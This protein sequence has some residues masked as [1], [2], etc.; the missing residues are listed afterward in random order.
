MSNF[1]EI[2]PLWRLT[3]YL[4][5]SQAALLVCGADPEFNA[6]VEDEPNNAPNGY[7]AVR[8][9]L[10][11]ALRAGKIEGVEQE[12][13]HWSTLLDPDGTEL[14]SK[15]YKIEGSIDPKT[16]VVA[17]DSMVE[18]L[19]SR[20]M[21]TGFFFSGPDKPKGFRDPA[22]PRYAPKLAA[23]VEAWERFDPKS[24]EQGTP[25]QRLQKWLRLNAARFGLV[26]DDGKPAESTIEMLAKVGNWNTK[27][28]NPGLTSPEPE[29]QE[30]YDFSRD[31]DDEIPY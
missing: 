12:T 21:R 24:K 2:N 20:G 9:A 15:A 26:D 10:V 29:P 30:K 19:R 8:D 17:V 23:I 5:I 4:T 7:V 3:E 18:W 27:G 6:Y 13:K 14:G 31:M 28:G 25:K 11:H 22:H 16:S 1:G